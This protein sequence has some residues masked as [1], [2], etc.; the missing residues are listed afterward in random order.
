MRHSPRRRARR[1]SITLLAVSVAATLAGGGAAW[2]QT[3]TFSSTDFTLAL[4]QIDSSGAS[5]GLTTDE[6]TTFLSAARCSCPASVGVAIEINSDSVTKVAATDS[7]DVTIMIGADCD[8]VAATACTSVGSALA[9]NAGTTQAGETLSTS[10]IF[11]AAAPSVACTALLATSSRLWAIVRQ[12]GV[13]LTTDPSLP[14]GVGGAGPTAPTGVTATTADS[15]LLIRGPRHRPPPRSRVTRCSARPAPRHRPRP[16][17]IAVRPVCCRGPAPFAS[18]S[19]AFICSDL[20]SAGTNSVRV[21]GLQNGTTYQVAVVS[22]GARRHAQRAFGSRHG[23]AGADAGVRRS[24]QAGRRH[25]AGRVRGG[26]TDVA[27]RRGGRLAGGALALAVRWC[28]GVSAGRAEPRGAGHR[29]GDAGGRSCVCWPS[30]WRWLWRASRSAQGYVVDDDQD[31]GGGSHGYRFGE[32]MP[33]G[34]GGPSAAALELRA[35]LRPRTIQRSTAS[36]PIAAQT[37]RPFEQ[38]FSSKQ[39]LHGG[40]ELDRQISHRGGTWA[41]GLRLRFLPGHARSSLAADHGHAH[42]RR[43]RRCVLTRWRCMAVYRADFLHERYSSPVV[44]LR[45]ARARLR[46]LVGLQ[47]GDLQVERQRHAPWAG[48]PPPASRWICRSSIPRG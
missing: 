21:T 12:N 3:A 6:L 19:A 44:P 4:A 37:A 25:R 42:R 43:D 9:L 23:D 16:P 35:A 18:L 40:L 13:R 2:A 22:I 41:V 38:T 24:L 7:F 31:D 46:A 17:S 33:L 26:G 29:S 47:H 48:T 1:L 15:G 20:V 27:R 32:E 10:D 14:I 11:A 36:S 5:Q 39:R 28:C 8:N 34:A 30:H 45:E